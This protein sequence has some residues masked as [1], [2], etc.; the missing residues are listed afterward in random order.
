M[1][2]NAFGSIA[3]PAVLGASLAAAPGL[4][5]AYQ[6]AQNPG[7]LS[8]LGIK[9]DDTDWG[10]IGRKALG[11]AA[12]GGALGLGGYLGGRL[13]NFLTGN[14]K[15]YVQK[16]NSRGVPQG[17]TRVKRRNFLPGYMAGGLGTYMLLNNAMRPKTAAEDLFALAE[18]IEEDSK[19]NVKVPTADNGP[20]GMPEQGNNDDYTDPTYPEKA[21]APDEP[22]WSEVDTITG[23]G[24]GPTFNDGGSSERNG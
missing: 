15:N 24:N 10:A 3:A 5:G 18:Q 19:K 21:K 8:R 13:T 16:V 17:E 1:N 14:N 23:S 7:I 20:K 2:K 11:G 4:Y 12:I 9:S 6:A 22:S